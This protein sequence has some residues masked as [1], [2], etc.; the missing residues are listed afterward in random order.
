ML[1]MIK[2]G[3]S[4]CLRYLL[5]DEH[6]PFEVTGLLMI[7]SPPFF[8]NLHWEPR[9]CYPSLLLSLPP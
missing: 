2:G 3:D 7:R 8:E 5:L 6:L 4:F 1:P 9:N